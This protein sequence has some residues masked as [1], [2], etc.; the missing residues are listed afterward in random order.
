MPGRPNPLFVE[1]LADLIAAAVEFG[2]VVKA[3]RQRQGDER[4]AIS[5]QADVAHLLASTQDVKDMHVRLGHA[6][7]A[8]RNGAARDRGRPRPARAVSAPEP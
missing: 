1:A 8:L 7:A 4:E 6:E 5:A 3:H 2:A